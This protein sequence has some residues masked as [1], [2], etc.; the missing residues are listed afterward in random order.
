M[1]LNPHAVGDQEINYKEL[2]IGGPPDSSPR[3]TPV[4]RGDSFLCQAAIHAGVVSD[5]RGGCGVVQLLG[6]RSGYTASTHHGMS[7]VGFDSFFP[8]SYTFLTHLSSGCIQDLRW[9][10]LAVTVTFT[11]LLSLCTA[12]PLVFHSSIFP[13][14]FFH[15]GLV[16]DPPSSSALPSLA[17]L[18]IGRF[19]PAALGSVI[20]YRYS[21][22]PQLTG[23]SANIEKTILWLGGAWIGSLNNYTFDFIPIQRLTPHDLRVQPGARLAL[24]L[25]ILLLLSITIGQV[26]YLRLEGRLRR[27]L[28]VYGI[29]VAFLLLCVA[30]PPL[31]LR[32]HHYFL[33]LLLLP[34]TRLQTRPSLLYQGI[35]VGLFINGTARWG[36]ASILQTTAALRDD[37]PIN[38]FLPN[39]TAPIAVTAS[40]ITFA[41]ALPPQAYDGLSVL[42]NDVE[43]FRWYVGEGEAQETF[44]RHAA[45]MKEY[46]RFGFMSGSDAAD[47][48]QAGTWEPDGKWKTMRSGPSL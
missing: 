6:E 32:I 45:G 13:M 3:S 24:V 40:N 36:F 28:G 29:F 39:I 5:A 20:I 2:V 12:S 27:Y 14:L 17:S 11:T 30:I 48:T 18:V 47:Y 21:V 37:G 33:A 25:I 4:Y 7:S 31:N 44:Q 15:V 26:Y 46:F 34:G 42:V 10:L 22:K 35:L 1:V 19:L 41:W 8:K 9:P 43:R 38:S 23:L 16:S